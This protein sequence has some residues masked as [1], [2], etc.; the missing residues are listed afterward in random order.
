VAYPD[1]SGPTH[2][3]PIGREPPLDP[4]PRPS[5]PV[6]RA[7]VWLVRLATLG[8]FGGL[9]YVTAARGDYKSGIVLAVVV[10]VL[11]G[12]DLGALLRAYR[13]TAPPANGDAP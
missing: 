5:D 7:P 4:T 8:S 9:L 11:L 10:L 3:T 6:P 12:V 1:L 13:G 2:Q